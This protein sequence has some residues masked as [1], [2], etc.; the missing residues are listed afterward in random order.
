MAMVTILQ[1][2]NVIIESLIFDFDN[3]V[4][5]TV[6]E[7]TNRILLAKDEKELRETI[8]AFALRSELDRY[9]VYAFGKH[10][11]WAN[12]RKFSDPKQTFEQRM[13]FVKF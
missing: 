10:H 12:Q 11:F 4:R 3:K 8:S 2:M 5:E 9:F 1:I 7:L 13:I 6:I